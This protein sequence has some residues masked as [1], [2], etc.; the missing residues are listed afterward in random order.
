VRR[1]SIDAFN[2]IRECG[3]LGARQ[4][5]AFDML[6][7]HGPMTGNELSQVSGVPGLWK[8]LSELESKKACRAVG[9]RKCRVTG[10][11]ATL[12]DVYERELMNQQDLF[13]EHA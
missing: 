9:E 12:W 4:K 8:R 7:V 13:E 2:A 1:T 5:L 3:V 11:L 10:R 6:L